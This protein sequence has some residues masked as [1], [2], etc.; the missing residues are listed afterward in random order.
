MN[1]LTDICN[2]CKKNI[3]DFFKA[4]HFHGRCKT[5]YKGSAMWLESAEL[6]EYK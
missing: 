6:E 2:K 4:C 5:F 3:E 1:G